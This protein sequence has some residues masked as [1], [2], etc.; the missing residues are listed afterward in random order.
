MGHDHFPWRQLGT[1][2]VEDGL[3]SDDQLERA[4]S[5]QRKTGRLLGEILVDWSFVTGIGLAQAL[6]KQHGVDVQPKDGAEATASTGAKTVKA[7]RP[8]GKLLVE[9]GYVSEV[10]L[11]QALAKQHEDV[12]RRLGEILVE[13]GYLS[14]PSLANAL[15]EQHGV[16]LGLGNKLDESFETSVSTTEPG[17]PRYQVCASVFDPTYRRGSSLY[18][19]SNFLEAADFAFEFVDDHAPAGL[20]I[21]RVDGQ[22]SETV[23][24]YSER[25]AAA[26]AESRKNLTETFGYDPT[27][28]D[29]SRRYIR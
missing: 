8:L 29:A 20:E 28:W 6:A 16:D 4:L 11:E 23:W 7:W 13:D 18:E 27:N 21:L 2:L 10:E 25:R 14:G 5:E 9:G 17:K 26:L 24:M 15:A 3:V 19:S 12:G 22:T 1:L